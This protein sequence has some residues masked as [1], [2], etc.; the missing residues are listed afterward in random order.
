M[1]FSHDLYYNE[2][3]NIVQILIS[4]N[5]ISLVAF[6]GTLL[7]FVYEVFLFIKD[8]KRRIKPVIPQ[9]DSTVKIPVGTQNV[10][11][12]KEEILPKSSK[13]QVLIL[14]LFVLLTI[15][16][17]IT[18]YSLYEESLQ[19]KSINPS[20]T[21]NEV[22]S[23]G[24]KLFDSDWNE[25][26]G[27]N[28]NPGATIIIGLETIPNVQIDRARIRVNDTVWKLEHITN[29]FNKENNVYYTEYTVATGEQKLKIEAELHSPQD[30]WLGD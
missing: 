5:K 14:V 23:Q 18:V 19:S 20:I 22:H 11:V 10:V 25:I 24:I 29:Q 12:T 21:V 7:F 6:L 26:K 2:N 13:N 3:M 8:K 27:G 17:G 16:G 15:F 1:Y 30:G 4:V 9:F 28:V